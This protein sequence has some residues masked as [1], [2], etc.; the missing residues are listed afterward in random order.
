LSARQLTRLARRAARAQRRGPHALDRV[1]LQSGLPLRRLRF[2]ADAWTEGGASGMRALGPAPPDADVE[3]VRRMDGALEA[4]RRR[5]YPLE[6]LR[7]DSW[8]NRLTIWHLLPGTDRRSDCEYRAL[9]HLR[10][11]EDGRW[12]LYRKAAQGEW[13]PVPVVGP[14][15]EQD[16]HDC[17]EAIRIDVDRVFWTAPPRAY[18]STDYWS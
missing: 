5:H 6:M 10:L 17:L 13:W 3:A 2:L 12:H 7:W 11:T 16:M 8:R 1:A 15:G 18:D 4:W 9:A 14:R